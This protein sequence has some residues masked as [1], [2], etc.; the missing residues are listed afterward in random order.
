MNKE[1][2][3][4]QCYNRGCGQK[5]DPIQNPEDACRHHPGLPFFH[6]AYK[7]WSCCNKKCT[8]FTEF[9]NIKG[10]TTTSHSNVKPQEPE[11]RPA[12]QD[13]DKEVEIV[14]VK[15][16]VQPILVRPPID[17]P[18]TTMKPE[19][20][21]SLKQNLQSA[22]KNEN[23]VVVDDP[24]HIPIGT[25]CKNSGCTASFEGPHSNEA[26]CIYHSGGPIFHEGMK[27]WSCCQ[28]KT[29]DFNVFL[30]QAGCQ[31]GKHKWIKEGNDDKTV[32][33][34]WDWHQTGSHVVVSIYAK[35]YCSSTSII[36]LNPIRV[37]ANLVFPNRANATF[38]LDVEL[39]RVIDV[40]ASQI[41]MFGTKV[42]MKLK[43]AE[44]GS[45]TKL[46]ISQAPIKSNW[47]VNK[48]IEN[49]TPKIDAVDLSDL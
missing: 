34:R 12:P 5:F 27:Y 13:S 44:P 4:L 37:F 21:P 19:L 36:Q 45:W 15:P 29:T 42:E 7:G 26:E 6:D 18:M 49:L 20:A 41:T 28:K 32:E 8:D 46:E 47:G 22:T 16:M 2:E 31:S 10:C 35:E 24:D 30:N 11:K 43:K 39:Q 3:L 48:K 33:C 25:L 9:L 1:A 17:T 38:T 40:R 23:P 14:E